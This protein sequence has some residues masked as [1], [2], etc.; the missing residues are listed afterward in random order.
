MTVPRRKPSSA[1]GRIPADLIRAIRRF[2]GLDQ[3]A[4]A[5]AFQVSPR[6]IIRWEKRG[7][8]PDLLPVDVRARI[9]EWRKELLIWMRRRYEATASPDNRKKEESPPCAGT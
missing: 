1:A 9:P 8:H 7:T 5:E 6:T 3:L 4:L 2:H